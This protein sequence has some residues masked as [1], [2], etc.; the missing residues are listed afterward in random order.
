MEKKDLKSL[1]NHI[2]QALLEKIDTEDNPTQ[3][4]VAAYLE[5]AAQTI[6]STNKDKTDALQ[7]EKQTFANKYKDI[8]AKTLS[9][10]KNSNDKFDSI[11]QTQAKVIQ[12]YKEQLINLPSIQEQYIKTQMHI[13]QEVERANQVIVN[14]TQQIEKLEKDS[15]LDPLTQIFNRGA[16]DAYLNR[17]CNQESLRY[18]LYILILDIDDFKQ[19]NDNYGHIAGDK[20]LKLVA[21]LLK[22]TLRE[23]DKIFR[24]GGE[25]FLV[26]LNRVDISTCRD[27]GNRMLKLISSNKLRYQ[28]NYFNVTISIGAT[29]FHQEDTPET[30][31]DRADKAMYISKQNGKNQMN[32]EL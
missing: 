2:C 29:L 15:K 32:M 20:V 21:N 13:S 14:L 8:A 9:S 19:V 6:K 12:D 26:V 10:Y 7:I 4:Q 18:A 30:L 31:I 22:K 23:G 16:L 1:I 3:W 24:Y 25:E 28:G 5:D 11:A 17:I 27:I